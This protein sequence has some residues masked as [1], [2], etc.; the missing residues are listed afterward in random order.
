MGYSTQ[1]LS[2]SRSKRV[3]G[4]AWLTPEFSIAQI[5]DHR[6]DKC[7][8]FFLWQVAIVQFSDD[9]RTEFKLSSYRDKESLLDAVQHITY[10]GGNTKTGM[11]MC[12]R[13]GFFLTS[14]FWF[15]RRNRCTWGAQEWKFV[16]IQEFREAWFFKFLKGT[17]D[18]LSCFRNYKH[19]QIRMEISSSISLYGN[20]MCNI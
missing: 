15:K 13:A 3:L 1:E 6:H 9:A 8:S 11:Y 4:L 5:Q 19:M 12:Q 10:K 18:I 20:T 17:L 2:I 14:S 16:C 7:I